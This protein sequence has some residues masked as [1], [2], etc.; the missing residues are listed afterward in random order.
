MSFAARCAENEFQRSP[1]H[2]LRGPR[3]IEK[4]IQS[5]LSPQSQL[6]LCSSLNTGKSHFLEKKSLPSLCWHAVAAK[7]LLKNQLARIRREVG[8]F[9]EYIALWDVSNEV[10]IM[11]IFE[12]E[13]NASPV[14]AGSQAACR[15]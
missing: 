10:V 4:H 15:W 2:E 5:S 8:A 3:F 7:W 12:K 1:E 11:P 13:E 9:S 6:S 14:C